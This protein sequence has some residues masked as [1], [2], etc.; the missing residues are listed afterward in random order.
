MERIKKE[1]EDF[2]KEPPSCCSAGPIGED[3]FHWQASIMG[4]EDSPFSGGV[5]YLDVLFPANYP[6]RPCKVQF[7]TKIYHP[8]VNKDGNICLDILSDQW[9]PTLTVSRVLLL[10]ASL[11]A[12]PNEDDPLVPEIA[13]QYKNNKAAYEATAREWTAR[14]AI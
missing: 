7:T 12:D 9:S 1:L 3:L 6:I 10:I 2:S 8:N 13:H 4:P 5:F 14:Y 11:L